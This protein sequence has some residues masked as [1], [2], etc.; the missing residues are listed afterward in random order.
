MRRINEFDAM[1]SLVTRGMEDE[2]QS[3]LKSIIMVT[4][5]TLLKLSAQ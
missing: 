2:I 5:N 4:L 3:A 1:K